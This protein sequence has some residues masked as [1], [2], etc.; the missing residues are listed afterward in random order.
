MDLFSEIKEILVDILDVAPEEISPESYL[1]RD[2][3]AESID[4]ME[5]GAESIDLME[6]AVTL[7]DRFDTEVDEDVVFLKSLR[8]E[9]E[10]ALESGSGAT[11]LLQGH[12]PYL[13][14]DRLEEILADLKD[15]PVLKVKDL[16]AY[17]ADHAAQPALS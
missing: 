2:L 11:D 5:L 4:L 16:I 1:I 10:D 13:S 3:G 15:G 8:R 14:A 17:M 7:N 9:L 12:Y 6:L